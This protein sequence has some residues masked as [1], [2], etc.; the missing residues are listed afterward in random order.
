MIRQALVGCGLEPNDIDLIERIVD[1]A[2]SGRIDDIS[3]IKNFS[4]KK[5]RT[6]IMVYLKRGA[7]PEVVEKQLYRFTP[8]QSTYSIINIALVNGRPKTLPLRE[9][10][11]CYIDHRRTV[12]RRR[13]EPM[14]RAAQHTVWKD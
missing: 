2:K 8:L 1:A 9:T 3:D 10:I 11:D 12:I 4:G 5:H 6:R 7:D 14:R 13:T